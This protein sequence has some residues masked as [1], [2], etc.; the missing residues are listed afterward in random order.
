MNDLNKIVHDLEKEIH[1]LEIKCNHPKRTKFEE[2]LKKHLKISGRTLE[3]FAP[4]LLSA[5]ILLGIMKYTSNTPFIIDQEKHHAT[6]V[7]EMDNDGFYSKKTSY[8]TI[9]SNNNILFYYSKWKLENNT[10][11]REAKQYKIP[12]YTEEEV[13][14]IMNKTDL[15]LE[16]I[17][18]QPVS[19]NIENTNHLPEDNREFMS[20]LIYEENSN[21]Y[22]Y[23][24]EPKSKNDLCTTGFMAFLLFLLPVIST[25]RNK[26]TH[27]SYFNSVKSIK[28]NYQTE[29][30]IN[31]KLILAKDNY[32]LLKR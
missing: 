23:V 9:D 22:Y 31:R 27:F 3:M 13:G 14:E 29:E 24:T 6:D 26:K 2:D 10:Y 28:D 5:G 4:Y 16:D 7:I 30:I 32:N 17:L 19:V 8:N 21:E 20:A 15:Q 12:N 25:I 11:V 1:K 18:G